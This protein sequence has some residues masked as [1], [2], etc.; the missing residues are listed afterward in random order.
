MIKCGT[1]IKMNCLQ[2]FKIKAFSNF[3]EN[4]PAEETSISAAFNALH[5]R[6][7]VAAT[8][9]GRVLS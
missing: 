3:T 5:C 8:Y 4:L 7:C 9:R 1:T 2:I 6:L